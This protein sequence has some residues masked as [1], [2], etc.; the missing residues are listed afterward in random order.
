[1]IEKQSGE[2]Q[3]DGGRPKASRNIFSVVVGIVG[4]QKD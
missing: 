3:D 4:G 2:V 1:M